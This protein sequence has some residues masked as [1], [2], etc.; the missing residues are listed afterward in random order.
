MRDNS[1]LPR[2]QVVVLVRKARGPAFD[3]YPGERCSRF[4]HV[5]DLLVEPALAGAV[6]NITRVED[7][8]SNHKPTFHAAALNIAEHI[9]RAW[10]GECPVVQLRMFR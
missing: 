5:N 10:T 3:L 9:V 7:T 4:V 6:H 1:T 8:R 2:W